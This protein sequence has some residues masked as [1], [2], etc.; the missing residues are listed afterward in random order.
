MRNL[1][2][3]LRVLENKEMFSRVREK[4][5]GGLRRLNNEELRDFHCLPYIIRVI[6]S[7]RIRLMGH[8]SSMGKCTDRINKR[9]ETVWKI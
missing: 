7:R 2:V 9:K 4:V 5:T 8:A 1:A 3:T 6:K